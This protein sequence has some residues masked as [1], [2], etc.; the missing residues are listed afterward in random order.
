MPDKKDYYDVLGVSKESSEADIKKAYRKLAK[1]YH[2]DHNKSADAEER[3][4]EVREA[5]EVLSSEQKRQAYDL[6]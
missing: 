1:E 5:Y 4:N 2:P 3:F 6:F